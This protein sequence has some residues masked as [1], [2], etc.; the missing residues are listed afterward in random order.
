MKSVSTIE[1]RDA[2]G[3]DDALIVVR[4]GNRRIAL[5]V[6]LKSDGDMEVVMPVEKAQTLIESLQQAIATAESQG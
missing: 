4:A 6:S 2:D 1:F 5:G 3:Q